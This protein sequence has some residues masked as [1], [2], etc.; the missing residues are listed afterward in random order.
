MTLLQLKILREIERQAFNISAAAKA[1][2]VA[3]R[4]QPSTSD[5]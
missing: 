5:A 2:H 4:G 3:A 1:E